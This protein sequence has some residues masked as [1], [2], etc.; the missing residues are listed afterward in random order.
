M[1]IR[2][3]ANELVI[4]QSGDLGLYGRLG[5]CY[6]VRVNHFGLVG[7][8]KPLLGD[9]HAQSCGVDV[10]VGKRNLRAGSLLNIYGQDTVLYAVRINVQQLLLN[11]AAGLSLLEYEA[12]LLDILGRYSRRANQ[13]ADSRYILSR[14]RGSSTLLN[15]LSGSARGY[16]PSRI[17]ERL[18][19][20]GLDTVYIEIG[21]YLQAGQTARKLCR[22]GVNGS[23]DLLG[24]SLVD[25]T[26]LFLDSVGQQ[27]LDVSIVL[28]EGLADFARRLLGS[29]CDYALNSGLESLLASLAGSLDSRLLGSVD[30]SLDS[31]VGRERS[32]SVRYGLDSLT[33]ILG[34]CIRTK[35]RRQVVLR[36]VVG[37]NGVDG[38]LKLLQISIG[39]LSVLKGLD[40]GLQSLEVLDR[41][42]H[43]AD[44]RLD[45]CD[46][47]GR[48][49]IETIVDLVDVVVVILTTD[50]RKHCSCNEQCKKIFKNFL[51]KT[52]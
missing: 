16:V 49:L 43:R 41:R 8:G 34:R 48:Q 40:T 45:V 42:L 21:N 27:L 6:E 22:H 26:V 52:K 50:T 3:F 39:N 47:A 28:L 31:L 15:R 11:G 36:N 17:L 19:L 38:V 29:T 14:C 32:Q 18:Q 24:D 13:V 46:L 51:H 35:R 44:L 9:G 5:E 2:I 10:A 1:A 30:G 4:N 7:I 37:L 33:D 20:D 12:G 23:L 25:E